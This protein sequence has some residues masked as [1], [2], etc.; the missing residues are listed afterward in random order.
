MPRVTYRCLL[1]APLEDVWALHAD[2]KEG[3][4]AL[5]P[6]ASEVEVVRADPPGVGAVV[7]ITAKTPIGRKAWVAVYREF[8]PP[9]GHR[10]HRLAWFVDEAL[11]SPFKSWRH[12]HRF[13]ET[14]DGGRVRVLAEDVVDYRVPLGP[15][16]LL[17]N[18]IVV[19]PQ[20]DQMFAYRH[21]E[22]IRRFGGRRLE[23]G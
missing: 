10:P 11:K 16:G 7:E 19:R 1:D 12:R 5:S 17:G 22:L 2:A 13:Q 8:H 9:S 18:L 20:L 21:G 4:E 3:L 6:P 15:L 14:V 23:G